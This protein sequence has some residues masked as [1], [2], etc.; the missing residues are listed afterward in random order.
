M[1]KNYIN[2]LILLLQLSVASG[3]LHAESKTTPAKDTSINLSKSKSEIDEK[4][5]RF[6]EIL[7]D[8]KLLL[9]DVI[10]ADFHQDTLEVIYTLSRIYDLLME[11]DQIGEKNLEDEEE[12]NRFERSFMDIYNFKL[13]TTRT[14]DAPIT[15]ERFR[16]E[17]TE[18]LEPVEIEMGDTKFIVVDDRDGHIPLVKNKKV[19]Q[20]ITY[21]QN[22]GRK[23]FEIWLKRY[24]KYKGLIIPIL[25]QH[26]LPEEL[27]VLAMIESGL[28][29]KA[30]SRANASGMWQFIYSTGKNYGL[31]R[32]WYVDERRD[33]TKATHA[34]CLY[35]KD[36][37]KMFDN[38]YLALAAYNGGEGRVS[39]ASRLHQTFD[40]W[41]LHS[42]PRETRNYIPYFLAAA[43]IVKDK[44]SYGFSEASSDPYEFDEVTLENSADL[45]VLARVAGLKPK[46]LRD[47]N[48]ELR[49]SA[50]PSD[51]PYTLKL[52]KN[53][54]ESFLRSWNS[55]PKEERFAP[56]FI[57]HRVRYGESLWTISKKY[58][59]SIHDIAGVNKIRNRHKI[60]IG[61]KMKIPVRG[62]RTWGTGSNGSPSGH[63]RVVHK[64]KAGNTLGQI[65]DNYGT[66]ATKIRRW[67]NMKYGTHLIH[68]G[69]Q[70]KIWVKE[71]YSIKKT[72]PKS[73][74]YGPPGHY[75]I[76]YR[77]KRGDTIGQIADD[78]G[79][80]SSR[81]RRW[82]NIKR[83][84]HIIY[85]GQ[86]L[87][88]WVK[89]G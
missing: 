84:S 62:G 17:M 30:Y 16:K 10:I 60:S 9:S 41:Q 54:K 75:K 79:I 61:Q 18:S 55:I 70:L 6:P 24:E 56:Q 59:V 69:Q 22:K 57:V 50:T 29:P 13:S 15:A 21:F 12:F 28:N 85:P 37:N 83:G 35:L 19:D 47:Y 20:F 46:T 51:R 8:V 3:F 64:V 40:F 25:E 2:Y 14:G 27:M 11:A 87:T 43:I 45:A 80:L 76:T 67:N 78:Y 66:T 4:S 33:P 39:R 7:N 48:P 82:N 74:T 88:L 68:T 89:E 65:A 71:G 72:K 77:V 42:L 81:I 1:I 49:Q 58:G 36:L 5:N 86:K 31:K 52:P 23:Q 63:Y 73:G 38:W 34:A 26:E 32:D 53:I 44:E